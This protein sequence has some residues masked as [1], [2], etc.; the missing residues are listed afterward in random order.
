MKKS[1]L[2]LLGAVVLVSSSAFAKTY[3][4]TLKVTNDITNATVHAFDKHAS[5]SISDTQIKT[6]D[7]HSFK[8][9]DDGKSFQLKA[10]GHRLCDVVGMNLLDFTQFLQFGSK[11]FGIDVSGKFIDH[12]RYELYCN[13]TNVQ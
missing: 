5:P 6:S 11:E 12:N 4:Y 9:A 7:S 3:T 8:V 2:I 13:L 1:A 10:N